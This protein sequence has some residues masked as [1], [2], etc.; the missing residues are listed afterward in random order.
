MK[1]IRVIDGVPTV[2]EGEFS[3]REGDVRVKVAAVGICGSDLHLLAAGWAEGRVL[4]HEISGHLD[5]GRAVALEPFRSCG[6]CRPCADGDRH[7]CAE[8]AEVM[9]IMADGGMTQFMSV[10]TQ[11]LVPLAAGVDIGHAS[12][13]ENLAVAVHGVNRARLESRDRVAVVG[14]GPIGLSLAAA[15]RRSGFPVSIAARHEH[16]RVA[17]ERIGATV[18]DDHTTFA[19][20]FDVVF[21]A[22]GNTASIQESVRRVRRAGRICMVGSFWDPVAIDIGLLMQEAELI[23]AMMYGRTPTGREIDGAAAL[24]AEMPDLGDTM[25]THRFPIDAAAEAFA[26]ADDRASGAIKVVFEPHR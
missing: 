23:P 1:S 10:P 22:V 5:D 15:L 25:I 21:D 4:G 14:A 13:V 20:G 11:A 7:S 26:V 9:G 12:L 24:L 2:E 18:I 8:G 16:Q 19:D 17:A 6:H 3:L